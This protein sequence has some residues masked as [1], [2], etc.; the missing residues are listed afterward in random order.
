MKTAALIFSILFCFSQNA[1][2][3][4]FKKLKNRTGEAVKEAVVNKTVEKGAQTAEK[5]MYNKLSS[6]NST[7]WILRSCQKLMSLSGYIS[8]I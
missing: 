6:I 1:E 7:V 3:Q 5:G 2:A 8:Y 4:F